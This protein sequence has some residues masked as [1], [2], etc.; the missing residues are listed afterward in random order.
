MFEERHLEPAFPGLAWH[1]S[2]DDD[3]FLKLARRATRYRPLVEDILEASGVRLFLVHRWQTLE[4]AVFDA[5]LPLQTAVA[6]WMGDTTYHGDHLP[7]VSRAQVD[8]LVTRMEPGD[9]I[10]ARRNWYV[11]NVGLPGFWPHAALF[12]GTPEQ[13]AATF[14]DNPEVRSAYPEGFTRALAERHLDAWV[15]HATAPR[16]AAKGGRRVVLEAISD[17]VVWSSQY[18]GLQ[19]DYVG[20]LRPRLSKLERA[21]AIER[22]YARLGTP[23]DFEFDFASDGVLVC[24]K[25]VYKAYRAPEDEGRSL[26]FPL[27]SIAGRLTLPANRI[28]QRY[29]LEAGTL[30]AQLEFVAFLDGRERDG[31][32]IEADGGAFRASWRRPKWD[33]AQD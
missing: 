27:E 11:S 12:V 7:L 10:I 26:D 19:A 21:R 9:V 23:Y 15:A 20:V 18:E 31:N 32:A 13:L 1:A 3:P 17:G 25:L 14:D 5:I 6:T 4:N 16:D 22:A 33:W 28:V 24:T 2:R 8:A 29:D 30:G